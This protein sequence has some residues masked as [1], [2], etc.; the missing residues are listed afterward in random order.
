M[1][2]QPIYFVY[3]ELK[4]DTNSELS[5]L[6]IENVQKSFYNSFFSNAVLY[7][8]SLDGVVI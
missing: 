4:L 8:I 3:T 6:A 7:I 1:L 2:Y 5:K